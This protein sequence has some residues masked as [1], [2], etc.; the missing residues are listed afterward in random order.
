MKLNDYQREQVQFMLGDVAFGNLAPTA[1]IAELESILEF[2][3]ENSQQAELFRLAKDYEYVLRNFYQTD[4][5]IAAIEFLRQLSNTSGTDVLLYYAKR[6][7]DHF[8]NKFQKDTQRK[9]LV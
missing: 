8:W 9:G 5:K 4:L 6:V 2:E 1:F 7:V 3:A